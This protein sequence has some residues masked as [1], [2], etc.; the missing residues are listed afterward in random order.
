MVKVGQKI[1]RIQPVLLKPA[2]SSKF[3]C[4]LKQEFRKTN[5]FPFPFTEESFE[6]GISWTNFPDNI[7]DYALQGLEY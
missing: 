1:C 7:S 6:Y 3:N 4:K 2:K 5:E